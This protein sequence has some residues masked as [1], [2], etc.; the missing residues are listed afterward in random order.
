MK[1]VVSNHQCV[2]LWAHQSQSH[3]HSGSISFNGNNI[4]SY[5]TTVAR[6]ITGT[7]LRKAVLITTD[8]YSITTSRHL[9]MIRQATNHLTQFYVPFQTIGDNANGKEIVNRMFRHANEEI[10]Q[11]LDKAKR[12]RVYKDHH[13]SNVKQTAEHFN[14]LAEFFGQQKRINLPADFEAMRAM[15]NANINAIQR[16]AQKERARREQAERERNR[17]AVEQALQEL[18]AWRNRERIAPPYHL[19]DTYLRFI[20]N[21]ETIQTSRGAEFPAEHGKR[22]YLLMSRLHSLGKTYQRNGHTVHCGH[23]AIDRMDENGIKAGCHQITWDEL[24]TFARHAGWIDDDNQTPQNPQNGHPTEDFATHAAEGNH[25]IETSCDS[26]SER[27]D[28]PQSTPQISSGQQ[29]II[30]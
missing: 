27:M 5:S 13:L 1:I 8:D 2:H 28:I 23:F 9:S 17:L 10:A 19:P 6:F 30:A 4:R 20:D 7:R 26:G 15:A 16:K 14:R 18:P 29:S 3:A 12:A 24:N 21:G 11:S 22:A 25:R